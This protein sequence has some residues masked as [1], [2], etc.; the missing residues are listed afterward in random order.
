MKDEQYTPDLSWP[1]EPPANTEYDR[2][3]VLQTHIINRAREQE[4][5]DRQ[6]EYWMFV[7]NPF[8]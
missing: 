4:K 1:S 5:L 3:T 2:G 7:D 8:S 6:Q